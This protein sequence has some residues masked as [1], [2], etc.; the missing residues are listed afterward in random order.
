MSNILNILNKTNTI[1]SRFNYL[2][3]DVLV[4]NY[5]T[6]EEYQYDKYCKLKI[7]LT[8]INS[9]MF[10]LRMAD[11]LP[12]SKD[13]NDMVDE[14]FNDIEIV[15][16]DCINLE[17]VLNKTFEEIELE[18]KMILSKLKMI[19]IKLDNLI[20]KSYE[21]DIIQ[22]TDNFTNNDLFDKDM[23]SK[24]KA[25]IETNNMIITLGKSESSNLL[26]GA[27]IEIEKY[28][29]GFPGNTHMV[30][31]KDNS[32]IFNGQIDTNMDLSKIIDESKD[33]WF[34]YEVFNI[35]SSIYDITNG[36]GFAYKEGIEWAY[37][38]DSLM[39]GVKIISP[40]AKLCNWITISPYIPEHKGVKASILKTIEIRDGKGN[41]QIVNIDS[42]FN[43]DKIISFNPQ[44]TKEIIVNIY[45][46]YFYNVD[47][48]HFYYSETGYGSDSYYDDIPSKE[49]RI[50]YDNISVETLGI[51]YDNKTNSYYQPTLN[52]KSFIDESKR[53]QLLFTAKD[54]P[55]HIKSGL[56]Y[57]NA[58][59][60]MIGIRDIKALKCD[61]EVNSEY[62][63]KQ[64]P[65]DKNIKAISF[66]SKESIPTKY[67][68]GEYIKYMFSIDNGNSWYDI[69]PQHKAHLGKSTYI[70]NSK[71]P[72][73][74]RKNHMLK[75]H[76]Y[77]DTSKID[78]IR[79]KIELSRPD[80][81]EFINTTPIVNN[82]TLKAHTYYDEDIILGC[83]C[84]EHK[85]VQ[86]CL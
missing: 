55:Q 25:N 43:E 59:R 75:N 65:I 39:L 3:K 79:V 15:L 81:E 8:S 46:P 86:K 66:E 20:S 23:C 58:K 41:N 85:V 68:N 29:N 82:F 19:D 51:K 18:R 67:P 44:I 63:S 33:T 54:T 56:E 12:W 70:I 26:D 30:T 21:R 69:L 57:F 60:Y 47:I 5:S 64:F 1:I 36:F 42:Y 48:G 53:N 84:E 28:S 38:V 14:A 52:N 71:I 13:L 61:F 35:D 50:N 45:Q 76:G 40:D 74:D 17:D 72:L 24:P 11:R 80:G 49:N 2:F 7:F 6:E 37:D 62:I 9:P 22:I 16:K 83:C 78:N 10:N 31:V 32:I 27:N 77:I 34:E 4:D 73:E